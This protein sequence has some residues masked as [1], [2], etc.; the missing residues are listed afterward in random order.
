MIYLS[1]GTCTIPRTT[2][3]F[4]EEILLSQRRPTVKISVS[5]CYFG[6]LIYLFMMLKLKLQLHMKFFTQAMCFRGGKKKIDDLYTHDFSQK[7]T[8]KSLLSGILCS[9]IDEDHQHDIVLPTAKNSDDED[10]DDADDDNSGGDAEIKLVTSHSN[11]YTDAKSPP[12]FSDEKFV[13]G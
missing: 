1:R 9:G 7:K 3:R 13:E 10:D 5:S 12:I 2:E 8:V 6:K 4:Q 11:T